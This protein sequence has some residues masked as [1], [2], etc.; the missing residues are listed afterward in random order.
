MNP[1]RRP[2]LPVSFRSHGQV[3]TSWPVLVLVRHGRAAQ[4]R[5]EP[6]TKLELATAAY[7]KPGHFDMLKAG[8]T[9]CQR[10]LVPKESVRHL[11]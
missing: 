7:R 2:D 1:R 6:R 10:L 4:R 3:S 8:G 9:V 11:Q 5:Q